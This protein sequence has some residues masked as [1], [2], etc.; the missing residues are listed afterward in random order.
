MNKL[1]LLLTLCISLYG[2]QRTVSAPEIIITIDNSPN[3][4]VDAT[5]S[6]NGF[7]VSLDELASRY[8]EITASFDKMLESNNYDLTLLQFLL[9]S[10]VS[11]KSKAYELDSRKWM[12]YYTALEE[13]I[14]IALF[15]AREERIDE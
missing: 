15:I 4:A 7:Y 11:M 2:M 9:S 5:D 13:K 8:T 10:C 6:S 14:S 1:L 3:I 12:Y